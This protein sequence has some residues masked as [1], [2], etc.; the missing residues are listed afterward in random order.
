MVCRTIIILLLLASNV[1]A[2][3][4]PPLA[5]KYVRSVIRE[6]HFYWGLGGPLDIFMGQIHQES[7]WRSNAQSI[8]AAG[9]TQFTPDTAKDIQRLLPHDTQAKCSV[10]DCRFD[11]EWAIRALVVYDKQLYD[12]YSYTSQN[13]FPDQ[14]F[15]FALA[16][17]NGGAGWIDRE[18]RYCV[19]DSCE[20]DIYFNEVEWACGKSNPHRSQQACTE[21]R[22]YPDVILHS[23]APMYHKWL[24]VNAIE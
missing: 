19:Q 9:L 22:H 8:Y 2:D 6:T 20:P 3:V 10:K 14:R 18:R 11:P 5:R 17:Y 21:N 4:V 16:G 24:A 15:A 12:H 1:H 13:D 7:R 23:W